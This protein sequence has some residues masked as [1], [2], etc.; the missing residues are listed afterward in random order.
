[1]DRLKKKK[2]AEEEVLFE[3]IRATYNLRSAGE[4]GEKSINK[5]VS[6]KDEIINP[7]ADKSENEKPM[8][9]TNKRKGQTEETKVRKPKKPKNKS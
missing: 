2:R 1:M 6:N 4:S 9:T 5:P 8:K 7:V 3:S